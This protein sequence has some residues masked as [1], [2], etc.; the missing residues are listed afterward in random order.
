MEIIVQGQAESYY[1]PDQVV[2]NLSFKSEASSY[3]QAL[4]IGSKQVLAFIDEI[5]KTNHFDPKDMK[6]QHFSIRK[7]TEYNEKTRKHDFV[8]YS[9]NQDA[10]LKFDYEKNKLTKIIEA[11]S[12]MNSPV[13]YNI[14][15]TV[16]DIKACKEDALTKAYNDA[17]QQAR[18][19]A[20][21]A[22]K[23]LIDC[24]KV[25]FKPFTN[26]Y[27]VT[28]FKNENLRLYDQVSYAKEV[29]IAETLNNV[30]TPEDV[31]ISETLYCLWIAE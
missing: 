31:E 26:D 6:T 23:S 29:S 5:L 11:I 21:A 25:D 13:F 1:T 19:I 22:N 28:G 20:K 17:H 15:F 3:D 7:E 4:L 12:L 18:M 16:K 10:T 2:L 14:S 27:M 30:F 24:V 9:Y 8:G